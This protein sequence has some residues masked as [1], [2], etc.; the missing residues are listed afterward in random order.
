MTLLPLPEVAILAM[1]ELKQSYSFSLAG[2]AMGVISCD[3]SHQL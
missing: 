3:A 1:L 2:R